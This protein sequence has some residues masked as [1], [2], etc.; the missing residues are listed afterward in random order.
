LTAFSDS[1]LTLV[2]FL[3]VRFLGLAA[4]VP[5]IEEFFLR[6]FLMR[7][8]TQAE[9]WTVPL[10]SVSVGSAALATVYGVLAHPAEPIAAAVWF[11]MITLLYVRTRNLW[12][13]VLAHAITN[14]MLG[15]YVLVWKD[16]T[17]W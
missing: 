4:V 6:G 10:G 11:T 15:V 14:A 16:W 5:L 9:W 8:F 3:V 7:F 17:L 2:A 13:C 12:D 1:T